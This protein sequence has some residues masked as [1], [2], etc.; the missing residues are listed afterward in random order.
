MA[1]LPEIVLEITEARTKIEHLTTV[2]IFNFEIDQRPSFWVDGVKCH[3]WSDFIAGLTSVPNSV[4]PGACYLP[5]QNIIVVNE[6]CAHKAPRDVLEAI[7]QHEI[8]HKKY[9]HY[10]SERIIDHEYQ[11]DRYSL[12]RGNKMIDALEYMNSCI[13]GADL[14][15]LF[16]GTTDELNIRIEALKRLDR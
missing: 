6:F 10:T 2:E 3:I 8:G 15:H 13:V 9:A 5:D 14:P 12:E 7:M 16:E 4:L 1:T 11:A